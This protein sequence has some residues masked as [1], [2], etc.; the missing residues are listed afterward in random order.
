MMPGSRA[1]LFPPVRA[2]WRLG[3]ATWA[4][5]RR[6]RRRLVVR[7]AAGRAR[8]TPPRDV[9]AASGVVAGVSPRARRS[10]AVDDAWRHARH[11]TSPEV[12]QVFSA[13]RAFTA[14]SSRWGSRLSQDANPIHVD[15]TAAVRA[16]FP[17]PV[18]HDML[19]ASLFRSH[20]RHEVP[21]RRV[22]H[23]IPRVLRPRPRGRIRRRRGATHENRR[24]ALLRDARARGAKTSS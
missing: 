16:G 6:A 24:L 14:D 7:L 4:P 9:R 22:R 19:C 3:T 13:E 2:Q 10:R 15:S 8:A 11:R 21:G 17:A 5:L 12:G 20:H 23:P 1:L 18:V